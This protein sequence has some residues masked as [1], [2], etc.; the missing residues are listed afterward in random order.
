MNRRQNGRDWIGSL[1]SL[2]AQAPDFYK[3]ANAVGQYR[4]RR[5][6]ERIIHRAGW[7]G[8]GALVGVGLAALLTPKTGPEIR[9]KISDQA[10][11]VRDYVAGPILNGE[12][13]Q[14]RK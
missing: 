11:R 13:E 8:A 4:R 10:G 12:G 5:R 9:R 14:A 7:I 6:A 2:A 1:T 3:L